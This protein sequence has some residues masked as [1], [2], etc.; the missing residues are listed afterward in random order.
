MP[1]T[2]KE[3]SEL[4]RE[5]AAR[6]ASIAL[7][8]NRSKHRMA[9]PRL[10]ADIV[11]ST[12]ALRK[13]L[14]YEPRDL[15]V[16]VEAGYPFLELQK[17]LAA[18]GQMIALD[19]P[20]ANNATIGGVVAAN[21]SGPLRR[22]YGAA[23]DLVIGMTFATLEGKLIKS[24][25]MVVKNVAG[26]DMG[27]LLIGSFGTLA[28]IT[29]LNFRLHSIP[30]ATRTFLYTFSDAD[31]ALAKRNEIQRSVLQP[32]ALDLLSPT[33]AVH[34][35]RRGFLLALRAGGSEA[36]LNRYQRE[37]DGAESLF[38]A[39]DARFWSAVQEFTPDFLARQPDGVVMR[40]STSLQ[41]MSPV[42]KLIPNPFICRAANGVTYVYAS[43]WG[44]VARLWK[45]LAQMG[46]RAVVEFAP[47]AIR[48]SE[49]LWRIPSDGA[50]HEA[51]VMMERV[52]QMFDPGCLLN[53]NRLYGRI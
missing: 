35:A 49:E 19:P 3:L 39:D 44:G 38:A 47:D 6:K 18:N 31:S 26:L 46:T 45:T 21:S 5:Q 10:P 1:A 28:A 36:V 34:V 9:G 22:A 13:V 14:D 43:S 29:S 7:E 24:G 33:A 37:L 52:K 15:T 27:K 40:I 42:L 48:E 8:G 32:L 30:E 11:I 16:S 12:S 25:G 17:L 4:L 51:F 23:R 50:E 41:G 2:A 20:F 53:R